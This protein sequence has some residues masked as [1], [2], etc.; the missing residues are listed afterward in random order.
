[1]P[2]TVFLGLKLVHVLLAIVAVGY[3]ATYGIWLAQVPR[4]SR[5][6]GLHI[7]RTLRAID[8]I[9]NFSYIGLLITGL[10]LAHGNGYSMAMHW[11]LGS[12]GLLVVMMGLAHGAYT[13]TLKKQIAV[14]EEQGADSAA[15]RALA[16][17]SRMIGLILFGLAGLIVAMMVIRP[18]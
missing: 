5:E 3:N 16:G 4:V 17:R 13:P 2:A 14:L 10:G 7:L 15:Y 18:G 1:M 9:A 12:L 8:R 6:T 11:I